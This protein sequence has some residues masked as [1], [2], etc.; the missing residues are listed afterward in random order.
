[1]I[2]FEVARVMATQNSLCRPSDLRAA[3]YQQPLQR[4]CLASS[5][6][7]DVTVGADPR[8]VIQ[9]GQAGLGPVPQRPQVLD[10]GVVPPQV[11]ISI[12]EIERV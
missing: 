8:Q 7:H 1:M 9:P 6:R 5:V 11:T 4:P 10:L 3:C 12:E 2:R